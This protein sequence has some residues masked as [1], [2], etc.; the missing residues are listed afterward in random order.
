MEFSHL[1]KKKFLH[2]LS[3]NH[4]LLKKFETQYHLPRQETGEPKPLKKQDEEKIMVTEPNIKN[5]E[6][7]K[8]ENLQTTKSSSTASPQTIKI[9]HGSKLR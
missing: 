1:R 3:N 2:K 6:K 9:A 4:T 5:W 7:K 8:L